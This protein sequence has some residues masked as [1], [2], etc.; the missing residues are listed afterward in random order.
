[1][2][3]SSSKILLLFFSIF[4]F[5]WIS[6]GIFAS[7]SLPYMLISLVVLLYIPGFLTLQ[8]I[9]AYMESLWLTIVHS[10]G[11]SI[12]WIYVLGLTGSTLLPYFKIFRPLDMGPYVVMH[13]ALMLI[14]LTFVCIKNWRRSVKA[15]EFSIVFPFLYGY[16]GVTILSLISIIGAFTLN[17]GGTN[18][19]SLVWFFCVSIIALIVTLVQKDKFE[20]LRPYSLFM[21]SLSLLWLLSARSWHI[22][23]WDIVQEYVTAT[24]TLTHGRWSMDFINDAYNACLSITILP[25]VI[26]N[27]SHIPIESSYKYIYPFLF[28]H[29]PVI[30]YF[31]LQKLSNK[32]TAMLS[33]LYIVA[34][35][36]FVQPMIALA[37]QEIAFLIFSLLL[38]SMFT[39][40]LRYRS[41][42][43]LVGFYI[44]ILVTSHYSTTYIAILL[45]SML[46]GSL[47]LRR[48]VKAIPV[49]LKISNIVFYKNWFF[50]S[51]STLKTWSFILLLILSFVWY[52]SITKIT[53]NFTS[54]FSETVRS[55][56]KVYLGDSKSQEAKQALPGQKNVLFTTDEDL[57]VFQNTFSGDLSNLTRNKINSIQ[58]EYP[59]IPLNEVHVPPKIGAVTAST[60]NSLLTRIKDSLKFVLIFGSIMLLLLT[61]R[62]TR[63]DKDLILLSVISTGLLLLITFHPSLGE[64]YNISRIY[65][66]LL[67]FLSFSLVTGLSSLLFL[68][69]RKIRVVI[70]TSILLLMILFL[71]GSLVPILGGIPILQFYSIGSDFEKFYIFSGELSSATWLGQNRDFSS[72]VYG[73][74]LTS[75]RLQR[76]AHLFPN[77]TIV[78]AVIVNNGKSYVYT[79][80]TN[81]LFGKALVTFDSK[82]I[83]YTYP[84]TL[85]QNYKDEVY[86][87]SYSS[88][89]K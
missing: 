45:F 31:W 23:G 3:I 4:Y 26:Q 39:K 68:L 21:L 63:V 47:M 7:N 27:I 82:S 22:N 52:F 71:Q 70:N 5:A 16:V 40:A 9:D 49:P 20:F 6:L 62:S 65:L 17:R 19:I 83:T 59:L 79:S 24:S 74:Y 64:K 61:F 50:D 88:I 58:N 29:F 12:G 73:D 41:Q 43:I 72:T 33:V 87:N 55:L 11:L 35:P 25:T 48:I 60:L 1:M 2:K 15:I 76:S 57:T 32:N 80:A 28:A 84:N 37:R 38:F 67:C 42:A 54:T 85:L 77:T 46:F 89:F 56:N 69:S 36:F 34:Q 51:S 14:L 18:T 10:I 75:L 81:K 8:A 13:V 66:Q 86:S 78:P 30:L 53:G 44:F